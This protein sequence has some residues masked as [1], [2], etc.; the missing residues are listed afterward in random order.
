[1]LSFVVLL[2]A[3]LMLASILGCASQAASSASAVLAIKDATPIAQAFEKGCGP[4][5][6]NWIRPGPRSSCTT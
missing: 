4:T 6:C 1:M 3:A 2:S 5:M